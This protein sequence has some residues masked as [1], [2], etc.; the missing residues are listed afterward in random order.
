MGKKKGSIGSFR[1]EL[2]EKAKEAALCAIKVYN[3]PLTRFKSETFIVL[4]VIAW[5]Y[6]LHAYFRSKKIDYRYYELKGVRKKYDRTKHKAYK[7]WELERCLNDEACPIDSEA[8]KNLRFLIALR[9]EIE[10]Q[11]SVGIDSYLVRSTLM[12]ISGN[13]SER[14]KG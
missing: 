6:L 10:H 2:L 13:S 7:F 4:M 8:Q 12:N 5:T 1:A 9:H 3:D 11:M 14:M